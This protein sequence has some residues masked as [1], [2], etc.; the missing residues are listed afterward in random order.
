MTE[1]NNNLQRIRELTVQGKNPT[2]SAADVASL[3][4]EI[5]ARL[6]E[7]DR[8]A[9]QTDFNGVK[10]LSGGTSGTQIS[11]QV[12]A[13]DNEVI[14][15]TVNGASTGDL[16]VNGFKINS[17]SLSTLDA[18]IS[19]ID[20]SRSGLGAIQNRFQS[21]IATTTTTVVNLSAARSRILDADYAT[22]VAAMTRAQ[23]L[24]QAGSSV[25]G[26]AIQ[27]PQNVLSL[28]R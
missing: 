26:Q 18:A 12:G 4:A 11:L 25:L 20:T 24:Q 15:F 14:T 28:L 23:I 8:V 2:N 27:I 10:I 9:A 6:A 19:K 16:G 17:G 22:E 7:I 1:A 5:D 21:T 3:Q 13:F